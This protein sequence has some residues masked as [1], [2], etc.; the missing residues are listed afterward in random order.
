MRLSN[1]LAALLFAGLFAAQGCKSSCETN[2]RTYEDGESWMCSCNSCSCRDGQ[3]S[4][5]QAFCGDSG[6]D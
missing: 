2:G 6:V 3:I 5:T 1:L 4:R